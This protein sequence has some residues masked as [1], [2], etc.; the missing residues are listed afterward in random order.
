MSTPPPSEWP[1]DPPPPPEPPAPSLAHGGPGIC[2]W[3]YPTGAPKP[4]QPK[5]QQQGELP[6]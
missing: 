1:D 6:L 5:P 4:P 3:C 2:T